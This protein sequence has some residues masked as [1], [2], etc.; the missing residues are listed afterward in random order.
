[1]INPIPKSGCQ[2]ARNPLSYRGISLAASMYKLYCYILNSRLSSWAESN[3]I[4]VDEQN[5]FRKGRSTIDH[6]STITNVIESR[7]MLKRSTY[8]AFID[9]RKAYDYINRDLLWNKLIDIGVRGR[10]LTA[11]RS[12][13]ASVSSCVRVNSLYTDWFDVKSGVRQ[14][15]I[16]SPILFNL[17]IN[18]LTLYLKTLGVGIQCG[19][20]K[21]CILAYADDIVLVA[22][23]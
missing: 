13:Y 19:T 18:D 17:F 10:M 14:G 15:C 16:L 3:N 4:L 12:L 21:I 8:C 9:F 20:D 7:K 5:G 11:I 2:D 6:L 22:E 23:N 1:M